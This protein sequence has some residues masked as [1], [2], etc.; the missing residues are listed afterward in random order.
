[1]D[2][3]FSQLLVHYEN[4]H[5]SS[6]C[7]LYHLTSV[8]SRKGL[9]GDAPPY[10]WGKLKKKI[11]TTQVFVLLFAWSLILS[12]PTLHGI[13][14]STIFNSALFLCQIHPTI[15]SSAN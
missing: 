15:K 13:L 5:D 3:S 12:I 11:L 14:D 10:T 1:M 9:P 4:L 2:I 7:L 6:E 8:E